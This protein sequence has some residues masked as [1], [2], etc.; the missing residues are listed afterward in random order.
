MR[1]A[2][3]IAN[4]L[5]MRRATPTRGEIP[6]AAQ[7]RG[8]ERTHRVL[9]NASGVA[10]P[11][12]PRIFDLFYQGRRDLAAGG[13]GSHRLALVRKISSC[14]R[15]G[16]GA[17]RGPGSRS[18]LIRPADGAA[19]PRLATPSANDGRATDSGHVGAAAGDGRR[20]T[21]SM[22][23]RRWA[24]CSPPADHEVRGVQRADGGTGGT[25]ALRSGGRGARHTAAVMDGFELA[26]A[27]ARRSGPRRLQADRAERLGQDAIA[28]Q[29]RCRLRAAPVS[30]RQ[31]QQI[32]GWSA[33]CSARHGRTAQAA[34]G[35][36]R[37]GVTGTSWPNKSFGSLIVGSGSIGVPR[38]SSRAESRRKRS[39]E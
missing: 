16:R 1:L 10:L 20:R 37:R 26:G 3:V 30:N 25:A 32:L 23:R 17:Q 34:T 28:S 21:T 4:L 19:A 38:P 9:D 5:R 39:A 31:R 7:P 8:D 12:L 27:S 36:G 15:H 13:G 24:A 22:V 33:P 18:E 35:I 11:V 6:S 14:R 2:Q 29:P